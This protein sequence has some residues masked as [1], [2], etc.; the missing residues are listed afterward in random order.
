MSEKKRVTISGYYG[1]GN[2]GDETILETIIQK[3]E[4]RFQD[5]DLEITV[6]SGDPVDTKRRHHIRAVNRWN[7]FT[8]I[9][10]LFRS[11]VLLSGG[12]GLLQD[13]TSS[14]SLWYYL[15]VMALAKMMGKDVYVIG[16]GL[17]PIRRRFNR[18]VLTLLLRRIEGCLVRDGDSADF[19]KEIGYPKE[20][21]LLG[22]DLAL[23]YPEREWNSQTLFPGEE[24]RRMAAAALK[25]VDEGREYLLRA[26]AKGMDLLKEKFGAKIILFSTHSAADFSMT[27][28]LKERME[29]EAQIIETD[30]L[31][32]SG[33][34]EMMEELDFLVGGR[35]HTL[36]FSLLAGTPVSGISYD[37][38]MDLFAQT[39]REL[40]EEA[41]IP[42]WHPEEL[43]EDEEYLEEMEE[44][45]QN[46][47]KI[48]RQLEKVVPRVQKKADRSLTQLLD[49]VEESLGEKAERRD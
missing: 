19:L 27:K 45:F 47:E 8:L 15:T 13:S 21:I 38:K 17:G 43:Q 35:L 49:W 11:D 5:L 46:R 25:D 10:T 33:L 6:L 41:E 2:L 26:V 9:L 30:H 28:D 36:E 39:L 40:E 29:E 34:I 24:E 44:I 18:L 32:A 31:D 7:P 42:I 1:Y 14:S 48:K 20:K 3:L 23:L 37:P 4:K 12:G 22:A 16:Q